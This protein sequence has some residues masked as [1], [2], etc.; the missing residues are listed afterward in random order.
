MRKAAMPQLVSA[1]LHNNE[2]LLP[3]LED[4]A[5]EVGRDRALGAD[6]RCFRHLPG[7]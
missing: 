6:G 4:L 2:G 5:R 3:R 1:L 7:L